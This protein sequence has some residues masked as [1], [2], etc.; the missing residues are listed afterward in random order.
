VSFI[1]IF[2]RVDCCQNR[3]DGSMLYV[4]NSETYSQNTPCPGGPFTFSTVTQAMAQAAGVQPAQAYALK[5]SCPLVGRYMQVRL[6]KTRP[7]DRSSAFL[8]RSPRLG[9]PRP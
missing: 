7:R 6:R 8:T 5:I 3:L 9:P 4:G 1:Q 2:D